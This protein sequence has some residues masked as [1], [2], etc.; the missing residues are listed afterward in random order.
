MAEGGQILAAILNNLEKSVVAGITTKDLD[1]YAVELVNHYGVRAA[2][3][4]YNGFPATLCVS[5]NDEVVHGIPS[6]KRILNKG[7]IVGL[8]MGVIYKDLYTDA[9]LTVPVLGNQSY[10]QWAKAE[11]DKHRLIE[12]TRQA[13][14]AGI[15]EA[16]VGNTIGQIS[17]AIQSVV[18]KARL[19][20]VRDLVGHGIGKELHEEPHVPNFGSTKE[21][22]VLRAGMVI[23]IEPMVTMG[24][25]HVTLDADKWTYRTKDGSLAAHFEHTV[26]ITKEGPQVLTR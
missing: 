5:V 8:D 15:A 9:A 1:S 22:P 14:E 3:L 13:L 21:G 20:I 16:R 17:Q 23:A 7:D 12:T 18:S 6:K 25:W 26:A 2:F 10:G 19:G 24:D 4:G 11:P